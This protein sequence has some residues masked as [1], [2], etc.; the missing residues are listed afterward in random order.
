MVD[1]EYADGEHGRPGCKNSRKKGKNKRKM[2]PG[3]KEYLKEAKESK[4]G[5]EEHFKTGKLGKNLHKKS[6]KFAGTK[7]YSE[8]SHSVDSGHSSMD[9]MCLSSRRVSRES[10]VQAAETVSSSD[11]IPHRKHAESVGTDSVVHSRESSVQGRCAGTSVHVDVSD[12]T[13]IKP[14]ACYSEASGADHD[15]RFAESRDLDEVSSARLGLLPGLTSHGVSRVSSRKEVAS[16]MCDSS[17]GEGISFA[18]KRHGE[19]LRNMHQSDVLRNTSE[20]AFESYQWFEGKPQ[21]FTFAP[22]GGR[23]WPPS[24]DSLFAPYQVM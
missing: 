13:A 4:E 1:G 11:K 7:H 19:M 10:S 9:E 21:L 14:E 12:A 20:S 16:K 23:W 3:F 15:S 17:G 18:A 2:V 5:S 24:L 6:G 22:I 8:L